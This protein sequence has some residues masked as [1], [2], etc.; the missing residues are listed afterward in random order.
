MDQRSSPEQLLEAAKRVDADGSGE[1]DFNEFFQVIVQQE[2]E[3]EQK[4]HKLKKRSKVLSMLGVVQK[5]AEPEP[6]AGFMGSILGTASPSN[7]F[8][9]KRMA[10]GMISK[11]KMLTRP[12]VKKG[13]KAHKIAKLFIN[14]LILQA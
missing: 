13:E 4:R 10:Q 11:G 8:D 9:M 14:S 2:E 1:I 5:Q 3:L 6:S 7:V 12:P